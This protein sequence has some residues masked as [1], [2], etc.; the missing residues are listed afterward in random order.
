MTTHKIDIGKKDVLWNYAATLLK[1]GVGIIVLPFILRYFPKETVAIWVIFSTI[2]TMFPLLDFGF[3]PSFSRNVSYIISGVREFRKEG[4]QVVEGNTQGVDYGL[5]KA[6]IKSMKQFY[7]R[8]A[9]IFLILLLTLGTFYL[10]FVL[11]TYTGNHNEVYIAWIILCAINTYNFYTYYYD[12]LLRGMGL[13]KKSKQIEVMSY[14][15]YLL[16]SVI[17]ILL[18]LNLIAVVCAQV[19]MVII[20][21]ALSYK[22]IYTPEFIESIRGAVSVVHKDLIKT[23]YP[24]AIKLGLTNVGGFLVTRVSLFIGALYLSLD[25]IASYGITIQ[26]ITVISSFATAYF[27]TYQ[28]QIVQYRTYG[29]IEKIRQIYLRSCKIIFSVFAVFG[30][31]LIFFGNDILLIL[32]SQT[33]LLPKSFTSVALLIYLLEANH[34]TAGNLLLTKNEVPFFKAS[35]VAGGITLILLFVFLKTTIL[36]VWG[37]ILAQGIAQVIYQNWKWPLEAF[38][39]INIKRV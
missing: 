38:K 11:R 1:I 12:A 28:P 6:L 10:H 8:L 26:I 37:L 14:L 25:I 27:A 7:A 35:L 34:A 29:N 23:I 4:H 30:L 19:L 5:L 39:D 9:L 20:K 21:R 3:N 13:I 36:G 22:A 15:A 16:M 32:R 24:N 31:I 17:L 18:N 33:M 2:I